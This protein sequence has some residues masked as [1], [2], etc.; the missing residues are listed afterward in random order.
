[1]INTIKK[2]KD[3]R[4]DILRVAMRNE[5]G[6][7]APSLSCLDILTV[8]YY[9]VLQERDTVI[10]SKGHGCYGLYA[11]WADLGLL[12]K[13][14]WEN[15]DLDGC[16]PGYGSLGHGLP[17]AVGVAYANKKLENDRHVWC[18]VGDGEMQEG[19][20]WEALSFLFHQGLTNITI[21]VDCNGLQ[22]M[23][24]IK[25]IM[26]QSLAG[27][28]FGWG[29]KPYYCDGHDHYELLDFLETKPLVLLAQTVKGK[30]V[31]FMENRANWHFRVPDG[32]E[33]E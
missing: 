20:N 14:K 23:D 22:A 6:H 13:D 21:I 30:G 1:M 4:R 31:S 25:N 24:R 17:V 3:L 11:I 33:Q 9:E 19:S 32:S 26:F 8:L 2:A 18:I 10:L 12:S 5:Q 29:I 7:I 27:R 15:F 28:F 16:L